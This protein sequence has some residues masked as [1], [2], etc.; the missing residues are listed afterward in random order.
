MVETE[1]YFIEIQLNLFKGLK[2]CL[3]WIFMVVTI[4]LGQRLEKLKCL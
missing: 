3:T 1:L 4:K 2:D